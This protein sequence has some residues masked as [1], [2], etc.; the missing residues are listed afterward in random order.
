VK[1]GWVNV[2]VTDT[3]TAGAMLKLG[4][5]RPQPEVDLRD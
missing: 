1:G 3:E 2:L 5:D 4:A